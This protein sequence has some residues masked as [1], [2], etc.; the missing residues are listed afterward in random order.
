MASPTEVISRVQSKR[1]RDTGH[2]GHQLMSTSHSLTLDE[3]TLVELES[4]AAQRGITPSALVQ[5][6]VRSC[7]AADQ[8]RS[9]SE[10]WPTWME[11]DAIEAVRAGLTTV[12]RLQKRREAWRR[13]AE[14]PLT[15]G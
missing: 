14:A 12:E 2:G 11:P 7:A 3:E 10:D 1:L 8:P 5:E 4:L 15:P 13:Q 9:D 6:L